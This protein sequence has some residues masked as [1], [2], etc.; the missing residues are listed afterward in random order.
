RA[1]REVSRQAPSVSNPLR[2]HG[3][4]GV[5]DPPART[6]P[7]PACVERQSLAQAGTP[8]GARSPD[9]PPEEFRAALA[10]LDT[11]TARPE[12]V[13]E[14]IPPPQR[15]APWAY[16]VAATAVD[17]EGEEEIET[18]N[19]RFIVL[20]DPAGHPSWEGTTRCVGYLSAGTDEEL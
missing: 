2:R 5:A 4:P 8:S 17:T 15:L 13:L 7:Y 10:A 19:G 18:A 1:D 9:E 3:P 11:V 12:I 14:P 16:A 6:G 20:Y